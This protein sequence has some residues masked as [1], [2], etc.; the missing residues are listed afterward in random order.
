VVGG[1][2]DD[3]DES[4]DPE[5][6]DDPDDPDE[7]DDPEELPDP[8]APLPPY[9]SLVAGAGEDVRGVVVPEAFAAEAVR[10]GSAPARTRPRRKA[11]MTRKRARVVRTSPSHE[12]ARATRCRDLAISPVSG[13][14]LWLG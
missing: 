6:P 14:L 4:D 9:G 7:S 13:S 5:D 12:G 8:V 10:P 1:A 11:R 3:P 2:A